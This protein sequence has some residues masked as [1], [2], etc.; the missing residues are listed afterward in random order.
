MRWGYPDFLP[1]LLLWI[2]WAWLVFRLIRRRE[3]RLAALIARPVWRAVLPSY[4]PSRTRRRAWLWLWALLA[5]AI[6]LAR[7]QWGFHWQEVRRRGLDI[8][9]VLDTSRSML[10]PDF[11]P[12]RLQHA[13]W[14]IRDFIQLLK[15]DRV[16]L[17][18][19]SGSSFLQ[20]PLTIDYAAFLMLLDD[21]HSGIIPRGGTAIEQGLRAAIRAFG[22]EGESDRVILLVSDGE[23]HEGDPLQLLDE[24]KKKKIRVYAIG[25]G[26]PEGELLPAPE[27]QGGTFFKDREGKVVKSS[28]NETI[29]ERLAVETGG[30]Y[31]RATPADFGA[32]RI[33]EQ[34]LVDLKRDERE[35]QLFKVYEERF[36][37]FIAMGLLLFVIEA[38]LP[39]RQNSKTMPLPKTTGAMTLLMLTL[40]LVAQTTEADEGMARQAMHEG[41]RHYASS[42]Y[43]AAAQ[44]FSK[45]AEA[46][47]GTS[48]DS[49]IA[50]YNEAT[51][52]L[53]HGQ[54]D[55]SA[56]KLQDALRSSD[57]RVQRRA[58]FNRGLALH[59]M[60]E[61]S[62]GVGDTQ[63]ASQAIEQALA[64]YR[65]ALTL[66]P[67]DVDA[68]INFELAL[69]LKEKIDELKQQQQQQQQS[70]QNQQKEDQSDQPQQPR[71]E[72]QKQNENQE[73]SHQSNDWEQQQT[74]QQQSA[75]NVKQEEMT[76]E[77]AER[78]LDAMRQEEDRQRA[79]YRQFHAKPVPVE[80]DW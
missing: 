13:K 15:A 44:A 35:S 76:T 9:V 75:Q 56:S 4:C 74:P 26:T 33:Y 70:K 65:S 23:D 52:L 36:G 2:P 62:V 54:A 21:V 37:W 58:W 3:N 40:S 30:M 38:V 59:K 61:Q 34:G 71:Q 24:L 57:L 77:E 29:L 6:A 50:R 49:A 12:S 42:N 32:R 73:S 78:I 7:P 69:Q 20:C 60:A 18:L 10:A 64:S 41:L 1:W 14:G 45:A 27:D 16:G 5:S 53:Q 79:Q 19:F 46:A 48:L 67:Q 17:V 68:K 11:R 31:A 72:E 51:A 80:K 22:D 63:S 55:R 47:M 66:A 8:V 28:L 39:S 43:E 25:I